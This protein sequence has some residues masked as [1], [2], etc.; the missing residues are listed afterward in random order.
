MIT[1]YQ[2]QFSHYCEKVRWALDYKKIP[3][4]TT[5][6]MPGLHTRVSRKLAPQSSLPIIVDNTTVVQDSTAIITFLEQQYPSS[7]T[8]ENA[9]DA[10][11]ALA[12]ESFLDME[13]GIP[14]RLWL[15][16]HILPERDR[17]LRLMLNGAPWY[18]HAVLPLIFPKI[19]ASMIKLM[20]IN[21][22][23]AKHAERRW[24]AASEKLDMALEGR[25]FLV[26]N[27]FSRADLTACALLS[28]YCAP[29]LRTDDTENILPEAVLRLREQHRPRL[30]FNWVLET[31]KNHR[32]STGSENCN[33]L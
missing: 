26:G 30:F 19:R 23:S 7:L 33:L 10:R 24:L 4:K 25:Q 17:A 14:L 13:V 1:L 15:Y 11:E 18:G 2:F 20:R 9:E 5:N 27:Q 8:P 28:P 32:F 6:L 3:Y 22:N 21:A 31:Y 29:T 16:H 12:W